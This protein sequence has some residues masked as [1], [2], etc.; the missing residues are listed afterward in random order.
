MTKKE[1]ETPIQALRKVLADDILQASDEEILAQF[2]EDV[3]SPEAN[4][5]KMRA[6]F[7]RTVLLSNKERLQAARAG[8]ANNPE[9]RNR[10]TIPILEARL[11]L[12][13]ALAALAHDN[14]FTLAAR[15]ESDLSDSDVLD[16]LETMRELG[17]LK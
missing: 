13:Q 4:A 10:S 9:Q 5:A 11:R 12:R 7:E 1:K 3:G 8:V 17:L 2:A 14:T 16:M 6:L 15:K